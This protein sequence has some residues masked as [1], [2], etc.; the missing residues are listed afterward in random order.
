MLEAPLTTW[1]LVTMSPSLSNTTPEPRPS[2]VLIW[3]T[4]GRTP[5]AIDRSWSWN[6]SSA[7]LPVLTLL[8]LPLWIATGERVATGLLA[9]GVQAAP[10][11]GITTT[12]RNRAALDIF[13]RPS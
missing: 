4:D 5:A 7:P 6:W 3:T 9:L 13:G 11:T 12:I 1:L 8:P 10:S 2:G